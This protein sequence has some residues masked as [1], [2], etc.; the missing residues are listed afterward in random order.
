[1][2]ILIVAIVILFIMEYSKKIDS[3]KFFNES[4]KHL[5]ILKEEIGRAH[6]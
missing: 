4:K 1:M 2:E 6:V 3:N 5:N